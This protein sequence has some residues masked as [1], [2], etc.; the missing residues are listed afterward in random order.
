MD[1]THLK[2][3]RGLFALLIGMCVMAA[4]KSAVAQTP[5]AEVTR[6]Q[7]RVKT[8]FDSVTSDTVTPRSAFD[9]LLTASP[10]R[11]ARTEDMKKMVDRYDALKKYGRYLGFEA[12]DFKRIGNDVVLLRYLYKTENLPVVWYISFYRRPGSDWFVVSLRF[13]TRIELLAL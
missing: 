11:Q 8:F 6:L 7:A 13:D 12:V 9:T 4:A 10:I 1:D 5:D 3:Q 2:I